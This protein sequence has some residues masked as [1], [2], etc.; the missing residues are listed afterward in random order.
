MIMWCHA[1]GARRLSLAFAPFPELF[2]ARSD[3]TAVQRFYYA[4]IRLGGPLIRLEPLYRYLRKFHALGR[5][6]YVLVSA[7]HIPAALVVLLS[8]E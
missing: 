7:R 4:L 6:R 8:L 2:D 3:H 1:R 5:R